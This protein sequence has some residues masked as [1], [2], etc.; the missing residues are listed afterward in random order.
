MPI[1]VVILIL[2][3]IGAALPLMRL[4]GNIG[5]RG[6]VQDQFG[7][8]RAVAISM[9]NAHQALLVYAR[10]P[11]NAAVSGPVSLSS[12]TMPVPYAGAPVA[13]NAYLGSSIA[14][15]TAVVYF[16]GTRPWTG[17]V[18][19]ALALQNSFAQDCGLSVGGTV[20]SPQGSLTPLPAAIPAGVAVIADLV[21]P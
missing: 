9:R 21:T 17:A 8:A 12:L 5:S 14:G 15:R 13:V 16:S 18:V 7:Y 2:T 4:P 11:G 10:V 19:D 20:Q 1:F 3:F 6:S